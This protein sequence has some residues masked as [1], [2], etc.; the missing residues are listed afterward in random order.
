M[1]RHRWIVALLAL[2]LVST[3]VATSEAQQRNRRAQNNNRDDDD[4]DEA[5]EVQLPSD[6]RLLDLHRDFVRKADRLAMEYE[7]A[8]EYE[9][10]RDV[11]VEVLRLV[12]N[13]P[14]AM[15]KLQ[16]IHEQESTAERVVL[17]VFADRPWQ[18]TGVI[19]IEGKPVR[20]EARGEWTFRMI[21]K[22]P[23]EGMEIPEKLRDFNLGALVGV[24][25]PLESR[26]KRDRD[27]D[28]DE[29]DEEDEAL[30]PFLI[31]S[32]YEFDAPVSGRL[33]LRMYDSD[34]SDNAGKI[35]VEIKG[36]FKKR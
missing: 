15:E 19:V 22:L 5:P 6:P 12:P 2:I 8:G 23:A 26:T 1:S 29:D 13:Y 36:T 14:P 18:D 28:E 34:P 24:I 31:G 20:I 33:L 3:Q 9:K 17:D 10:A 4:E 25:E 30:Q 11:Y 32:K 21:Y 16:R 27:K 35:S 7:K